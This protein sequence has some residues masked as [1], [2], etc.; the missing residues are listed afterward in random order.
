MP[1]RVRARA[2]APA[3]IPP[4]RSSRP[5][6]NP[7]PRAPTV[8]A[9]AG[10]R[11]LRAWNAAVTVPSATGSGA[12]SRSCRAKTR[13]P[14][15]RCV[16]PGRG[17][18][19]TTVPRPRRA[20]PRSTPSSRRSGAPPG[21]THSRSACSPRCSRAGD[22]SCRSPPSAATGPGW[23]PSVRRRVPRSTPCTTLPSRPRHRPRARRGRR[24][25]TT[26]PSRTRPERRRPRRGPCTTVPSGS[27]R[28]SPGQHPARCWWVPCRR[29]SGSPA[30]R[31]GPSRSSS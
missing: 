25:C 21:S 11:P 13:P 28:G 17:A 30:G 22:P 8:P 3:G 26:V 10:P 27:R 12:P 16:R 18:S 20:P 2:P 29:P 31:A 23:R 15:R 7:P 14:S 9:R 4:C 24:A 6:R 1:G 19:R 5:L